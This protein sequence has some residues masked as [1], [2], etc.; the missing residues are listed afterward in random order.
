MTDR[1][2]DSIG[3]NLFIV[4]A[5]L[6]TGLARVLRPFDITPEQFATLSLLH[7]RDGIQQSVISDLLL[8]DRPNISRILERLQQKKL[9]RRQA[10]SQ[11]RRAIH[12]Y[13]TPS[14]NKM[15]SDIEGSVAEFRAQAYRGLSRVEQQHLIEMLQLISKNLG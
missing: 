11:D 1:I 10:D 9:V 6:K 12:V 5:G 14:G 8:K 7:E 13:I 2:Q 15:F 4:A 3:F